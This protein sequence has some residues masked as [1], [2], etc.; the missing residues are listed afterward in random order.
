V[1][2]KLPLLEPNADTFFWMQW[3]ENGHSADATQVWSAYTTAWH[4]SDDLVDGMVRDSASSGAVGTIERMSSDNAVDGHSGGGFFFNGIAGEGPR[5]SFPDDPRFDVPPE[6][7][8]SIELWLRREP[9]SSVDGSLAE[10]EGC[11]LGWTLQMAGRAAWCTSGSAPG[12]ASPTAAAAAWTTTNFPRPSRSRE[13]TATPIG[14][15]RC[16][17]WIARPARSTDTSTRARVCPA[18]S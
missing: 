1:W 17:R 11:C 15:M 2:V 18:R 10:K 16:R 12:A 3:G 13:A 4:L 7:A 8:R 5:V 9:G 14:T 6:G